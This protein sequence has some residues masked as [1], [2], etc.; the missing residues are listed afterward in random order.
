MYIR[1]FLSA[2]EGL[3]ILKIRIWDGFVSVSKVKVCA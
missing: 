2:N 3:H 1:I